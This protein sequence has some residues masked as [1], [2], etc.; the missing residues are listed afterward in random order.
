MF[1]L[2]SQ[3]SYK[4]MA[5]RR[6]AY[7]VSAFLL[8]AGAAGWVVN[9]GFALGIDFTGGLLIEYEFNRPV[10]IDKARDVV[11]RLGYAGAEIQ[12]I[13]N[14]PRELMIRVPEEGG[15]AADEASPSAKI[16][17]AL[18]AEIPGLT[19]D[20]RLEESVGPKIGQELRGKA[21]WAVLISLIGILLYITIRFEWKFAVAA[22][23]ALFHDVAVVLGVFAILEREI[24]LPLIAALLTI[25]GYSVNDT[26]VI[27]DRVREQLK[28]RRKES[29]SEVIDISVNQT[30]SR[31]IITAS[32]TL[33]AVLA[34]LLL[35]GHVI[36]DFALAMFLGI[37]VG[38][39]SSIFVAS[40][41][42]LEIDQI[43][44]RPRHKAPGRAS[45]ATAT[46]S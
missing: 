17:E 1:Q 23:V 46:G 30:L 15:R 13:A 4:F 31:T 11:A 3:T 37:I 8:I 35:G 14:D 16:L 36:H 25:G 45:R 10:P 38:T 41:M 33:F 12:D 19:G 18:Q 34:L 2:L 9:G 39:Y 28:V 7:A 29:F 44:T 27:F 21:T 6:Y 20:L 40:A 32:T 22:V 24:T 42:A 26:I 43:V 5:V